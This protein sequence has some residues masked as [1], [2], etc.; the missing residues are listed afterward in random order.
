LAVSRP[1]PP[2]SQQLQQLKLSTSLRKTESYESACYNGGTFQFLE[3]KKAGSRVGRD[4]SI[5]V[6]KGKCKVIF[7][8]S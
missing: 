1:P 5:N 7:F 8:F 6:C 3:P 2:F 4:D